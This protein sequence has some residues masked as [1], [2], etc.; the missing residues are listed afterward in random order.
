[1]KNKVVLILLLWLSSLGVWAQNT[2]EKINE[3]IEDAVEFIQQES[4][5]EDVDY[6]ALYEQ[7]YRLYRIQPNLNKLDRNE[8]DDLL[9]LSPLT[10]TNIITYRDKYGGFIEEVELELIPGVSSNEVTWLKT[11]TSIGT[12]K[13]SLD[14][15]R[16]SKKEARTEIATKISKDLAPREGYL[17][18][19]PVYAG[20]AV[21]LYTRI[22]YALPSKLTVAI[23]TEKDPGETY[24]SKGNYGLDYT[25]GHIQYFG[26]GLLQSAVVGDFQYTQGQGLLFNNRLGFNKSAQTLKVRKTFS[27]Y[28]GY[29][30]VNENEF[31]RGG[32]VR[33]EKKG[34]QLN[35][36]VSHKKVDGNVDSLTQEVYSIYTSG[37]HRTE[38]EIARK[39]AIN[40][41]IGFVG[42][43]KTMDRL[44]IGLSALHYQIQTQENNN[45][46]IGADATYRLNRGYL[47]GEVVQDKQS[48]V[49]GIVG[50]VVS[51]NSRSAVTLAYRN[52]SPNFENR[53]ANPFSASG[54]GSNERG[55][56]LGWELRLSQKWQFNAYFDQFTNPAGNRNTDFLAR[57]NDWL[58]QLQFTERK[59]YSIYARVR[60]RLLV[61]DEITEGTPFAE[62]TPAVKWN[63]RIHAE[64][65]LPAG[66][67]LRSRVEQV[68]NVTTTDTRMG[69]LAYQDL[70]WKPKEKPYSL[71]ARYALFETETFEERVYAFENDLL[72]SYSIPAYYYT[73]QRAYLILKTKPIRR[74]DF[75]VRYAVWNYSSQNT[76][77]SGNDLIADNRKPTL[78]MLLRYKF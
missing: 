61:E 26:D 6:T 70:I 2:E 77:G 11:F 21:K 72:Y 46:L 27:G 36:F 4:V 9:F 37:L 73:G 34:W 33:L 65:K 45:T 38:N 8:L 59:K 22:K 56:Y 5:V 43:R 78:S 75:W 60:R 64:F 69:V 16:K 7:L 62:Q 18:D 71:T 76:I 52:Y 63:A 20:D 30:S 40:E 42:I 32:G 15:I 3:I 39:D 13:F 51:L 35:S 55:F 19:S 67:T 41:S 23:I 49:S 10:I 54:R 57:Q 25:S 14:E 17:G 74:F 58:A 68:W 48:H 28:K 50:M 53:Y 29:T 66:F 44:D 1:M 31:L 24:Y 47:F 12:V